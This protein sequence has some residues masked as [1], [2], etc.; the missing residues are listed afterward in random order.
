MSDLLEK[1]L[2]VHGGQDNW[3]RVN[4]VDFRLTLRGA[5]L[6]VKKQPQGL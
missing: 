2:D 3:Q 6:E 1:V 5:A 4:A